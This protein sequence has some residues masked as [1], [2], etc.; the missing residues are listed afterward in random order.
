MHATDRARS[1]EASAGAAA[2]GR[3]PAPPPP[4][5]E[6]AAVE[7]FVDL[8]P[9]PREAPPSTDGSELQD[10]AAEPDRVVGRDDPPVLEAADP[11]EVDVIREWPIGDVWAGGRAARRGA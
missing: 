6:R 5:D 2:G 10:V 3:A 4:G 9:G 8:D 7:P 1:F 11:L